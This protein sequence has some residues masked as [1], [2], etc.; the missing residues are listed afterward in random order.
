MRDG[1][2]RPLSGTLS[3]DP[4]RAAQPSRVPRHL[5]F[6][7]SGDDPEVDGR[8]LVSMTEVS[9][10]G[11]PGNRVAFWAPEGSLPKSE[12]AHELSI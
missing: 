9:P 2:A 7:A 11:T 5:E 10:I 1:I 8:V 12:V 6:L 4:N 3:T